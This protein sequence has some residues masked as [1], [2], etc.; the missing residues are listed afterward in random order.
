MKFSFKAINE[1]RRVIT[2]YIFL[3]HNKF[4]LNIIPVHLR[5]LCNYSIEKSQVN[6]QTNKKEKEHK[7]ISKCA[8]GLEKIFC[9]SKIKKESIISGKCRHKVDNTINKNTID[10]KIQ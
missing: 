2:I 4:Y 10:K 8:E 3:L 5:H 7:K 9:V 1:K 6:T